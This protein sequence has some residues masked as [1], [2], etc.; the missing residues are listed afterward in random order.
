MMITLS[1]S[2]PKTLDFQENLVMQCQIIICLK[3]FVIQCNA[4][5][6]GAAQTTYTHTYSYM[7]DKNLLRFL[8]HFC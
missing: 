4:I 2:L 3:T 7:A 6:I 5:V 1:Y 8:T